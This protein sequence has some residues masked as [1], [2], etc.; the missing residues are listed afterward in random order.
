MWLPVTR[1]S[2][3]ERQACPLEK[4]VVAK[5]CAKPGVKGVPITPTDIVLTTLSAMTDSDATRQGCVGGL[6]GAREAW[7]GSYGAW[8]PDREVW[9][10][11]FNK[12]DHSDM[13]EKHQEKY[14]RRKMGGGRSYTDLPGQGVHGESAVPSSEVQPMA[15]LAARQRELA[16]VAQLRTVL[17]NIERDIHTMEPHEASLAKEIKSN[18]RWLRRRAAQIRKELGE[19]FVAADLTA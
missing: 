1:G 13:Y 4:G 18:L 2:Q 7:E 9:H 10:I 16:A 12:G 11:D 6:R 8:N 15:E 5:L 3:G 19:P 17:R 14:L